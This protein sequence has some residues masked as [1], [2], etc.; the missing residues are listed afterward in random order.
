MDILPKD[1]KNIIIGY[2]TEICYNDVLCEL[3]QRMLHI[4]L[5]KEIFWNRYDIYDRFVEKAHIVD[6]EFT[7]RGEDNIEYFGYGDD[8]YMEDY[9]KRFQ[10]LNYKDQNYY[11]DYFDKYFHLQ[12]ID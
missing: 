9:W 11:N 8:R 2:K 6:K 10:I 3:K 5:M 4:R 7:T 12:Y 1:I